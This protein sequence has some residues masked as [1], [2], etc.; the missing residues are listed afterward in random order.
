MSCSS[1]QCTLLQK[2]SLNSGARG[3]RDVYTHGTSWL[4]M[5][6]G[7]DVTFLEHRQRLNGGEGMRGTDLDP[8]TSS[9][10][11]IAGASNGFLSPAFQ[12]AL[13]SKRTLPL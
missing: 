9:L 6:K 8:V 7:S 1:I 5:C 3:P 13:L 10:A 11:L 2:D 12:L 4:C